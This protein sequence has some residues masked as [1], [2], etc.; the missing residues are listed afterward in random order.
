M[1]IIVA[2]CRDFDNYGVAKQC[3]SH[4]LTKFPTVTKNEIEFVSGHAN[5]ADK[6][7]E[8][9]AKEFGYKLKLFPADWNKYG[10]TA[11]IIRNKQM[12]DYACSGDVLIAFWDNKSPG[13]KNMIQVAKKAGLRCFVVYI[14]E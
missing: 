8:K 13:T 5:G 14:K 7:G 4:L 3:I 12:A 6:L 9:Y 10:K 2:G 11:G 1:K